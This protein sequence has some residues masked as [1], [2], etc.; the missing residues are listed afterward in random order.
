MC[1]P[2]TNKLYPQGPTYAQL[3]HST[4]AQ[5]THIQTSQKVTQQGIPHP[6]SQRPEPSHHLPRRKPRPTRLTNANTNHTQQERF[7]LPSLRRRFRPLLLQ[8]QFMGAGGVVLPGVGMLHDRKGRCVPSL[9]TIR[10]ARR[11]HKQPRLA[12]APRA[13]SLRQTTTVYPAKTLAATPLSL[14]L[15][16]YL[17][18]NR[19]THA[20]PHGVHFAGSCHVNSPAHRK[21]II[22]P[23]SGYI[24]FSP[25]TM[26]PRVNHCFSHSLRLH[27]I[28]TKNSTSIRVRL[29][30][31]N[32][33][34]FSLK[35]CNVNFATSPHRTSNIIIS[36]PVA[37]GVT[38]TL[39][40]YYSTITSPGVLIIYNSRTYSN[41]LFTNDHTISH[42]FFSARTTSL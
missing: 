7:K 9:S 38:R 28:Y 14:S 12:R 2:P 8:P 42:A 25:T 13:A 33:I 20:T 11:F 32:G 17:F 21:L 6:T 39:Q 4:H 10:L 22:Q 27:R 1:Q 31:A 41:N 34:G 37:I 35:H 15:N 16:H 19:Y 40:V 3:Y 30:T 29:G 23:N 18:Y 24:Q 36:N 5:F 26:H